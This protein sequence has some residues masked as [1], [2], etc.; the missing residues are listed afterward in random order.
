MTYSGE[1]KYETTCL[2]NGVIALR[3]GKNPLLAGSCIVSGFVEQN[4]TLIE[5]L[6]ESP[7]PFYLDLR[8]DGVAMSAVPDSVRLIRQELDMSS[9]ELLTE[10]EWVY[11]PNSR[12]HIEVT[13]FV[14]R[15]TPTLA[16]SQITLT[17][18]Q[19]CR[20]DLSP[21][22]RTGLLGIME[23]TVS[24]MIAEKMVSG[25]ALINNSMVKAAGYS[26][27]LN[28]LGVAM[29]LNSEHVLKVEQERYIA[30][31]TPGTPC[32]LALIAA[33]IAE[34][35]T[36]EP[37]LEAIRLARWGEMLSAQ[38][39]RQFNREAWAKIWE[40]RVIAEG[41]TESEQL[42]I[43]SSFYYLQS[44]FHAGMIAGSAPYGLT[45][46]AAL[47][48]HTFW[49]TDIWMLPPV[50]LVQPEA[51]RSH[52]EFRKNG[53][54]GARKRAK[55]FGYK[56]AQYPWQTTKDGY[57]GTTTAFA[58]GWSEQ[59]V[60]PNVAVAAWMYQQIAGD[61][62]LMRDYTWHILE[63]VADWITSR[64]VWTERGFEVHHMMGVDEEL[65]N[66]PNDGYFNIMAK[67]A[68]MYAIECAEALDYEVDDQWRRIAD[69]FFLPRGADGSYLN[70]DPDTRIRKINPETLEV[71]EKMGIEQ[72]D[73]SRLY[74][75]VQYVM[76]FSPPIDYDSLKKVYIAEEAT[77]H[78]WHS[79]SAAPGTPKSVSFIIPPFSTRACFF[80]DRDK[81][82]EL[83][84]HSYED[85]LLPPFQMIREYKF[86]DFGSYMTTYGAILSAVM[87]GFTGL[88]PT[89]PGYI[90]FK[91]SLPQGWN[92]IT[93]GKITL[94]G[95]PYR[96]DAEHGEYATIIP[97]DDN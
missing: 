76:H 90:K 85:Y 19:A 81:G 51:A 67:M 62:R 78:T 83:F 69:Q 57:E 52:I 84:R 95:K 86:F 39:L 20:V 35:Y 43:D 10:L 18:D 61:M 91:S 23:Y 33:F 34:V 53:L 42:I 29:I 24:S 89:E 71:E 13:Q 66:V 47:S 1:G 3:P 44:G 31:L 26:Y 45:Q 77:R 25:A 8:L 40:S 38:V 80:G 14:S 37:H 75:R 16:V 32:E 72:V 21:Q 87:M 59:H 58:T 96:L 68:V 55:L 36:P 63:G 93:I 30:D 54:E 28:K 27:G 15:S 2:S 60:T 94:G 82:L 73:P 64:G 41:A 46:N 49:D 6:A 92:R 79:Y 88:R 4:D 17:S 50:A 97:L 74:F 22:I 12:L 48:G 56:G 5:Q 9:G 65:E 7:Y 11:A 70:F